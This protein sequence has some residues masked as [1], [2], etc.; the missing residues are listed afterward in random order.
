MPTPP[1]S[2]DVKTA[3]PASE[4][5]RRPGSD[6]NT[7]GSSAYLRAGVLL[8]LCLAAAP[9]TRPADPQLWAEMKQIDAAAGRAAAVT[10]DFY[11]EKFTPLMKRPLV[12]TGR[13]VARG[14]VSLW[15]TAAPR[16]SVMRVTADRIRIYYPDQ[17]VV[18]SYPVQ[19]QLGA[20]VASPLP[21]LDV[22]AKFF[23]FD[24]LPNPDPAALAVRL[25][26]ATDDLRQHVRRVDV[27]LDRATGAIRRAE[28]TDADGD[29][30]VLTFD[31]ADL[32]A[33]V[34]DGDLELRFPPNTRQVEPLAGLAPP[35]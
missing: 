7:P 12:S 2:D 13:V 3:K 24:R 14:P 5:R 6:V 29:R 18:E 22:L 23:T 9:A 34:A 25:T 11:Q 16:P 10:A 35:E 28:T 1:F 17:A 27:T 31:H 32:R 8:L 26:P 33:P 21:R 4:V 30:T 15:T 19:G 20:L